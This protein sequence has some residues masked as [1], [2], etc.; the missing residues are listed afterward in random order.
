MSHA[1]IFTA[2]IACLFAAAMFTGCKKG[3]QIRQCSGMIWSTTYNITYTS[4]RNLD[5]SILAVMKRVEKSL[6]PFDRNSL[7]SAINRGE[8]TKTDALL[9]RIFTTSQ[10]INRRSGGAFDPTVAPLVNLWGFGYDNSST[11][12][13]TQAMIDSALSLVGINR[14]AIIADTMVKCTPATQFNFSAITKGYGCDLVGEM[15]IR[16]GC[17][18]YMVEIGGEIALSGSNPKNEPWHIQIDAPIEDNSNLDHQ[19]LTIIAIS[20]CGIATS[21]N[22]RNFHQS[23]SGKTWHTIDPSTGRPAQTT[24]LS[25]TVIASDCMTA[26][27]LATACMAMPV[28]KALEMINSSEN[29]EALLVED[30]GCG[31][32]TLHATTDFPSL[33]K[34]AKR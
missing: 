29:V 33:Q 4:D 11:E 7:I 23:E 22:Y 13:P 18:D 19:A 30:N 8:S 2:A 6:S 34:A 25:A 26:D 28:E 10:E 17:Q 21:G 1:R 20:N 14:C 32:F 5:D 24:T 9:R 12:P 31:G 16:N 3:T 27:A 15:L